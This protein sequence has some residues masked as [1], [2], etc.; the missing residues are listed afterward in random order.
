MTKIAVVVLNYNGKKFLKR[1]LPALCEN[2]GQ[3]GIIVADNK[4]GDD[5]IDFLAKEF[6]AV[7]L[8]QFKENLGFAGG[9]NKALEQIEAEYFA[10][11]NSDVEVSSNW[12]DPL[13]EFLESNDEYAAVQPKIK[14]GLNK[15]YFEHAGA[16]GGFV[17]ALGYPFCR[18]RIFQ[19]LEKDTGQYD[20]TVDIDWT[21]GACMLIRSEVFHQ[22]GGFDDNF[23]SHMEEIDLCWRIRSGGMKLAC[24]PKSTVYHVGGGTLDNSSP[25]KTYL[26]FRNGLSLLVKNLPLGQL[27]WKLPLRLIL[28]GM[29]AIKITFE[30]S[31]KH[32]WAIL[33]A[34]L[35]FYWELPRTLRK[36]R[37]TSPPRNIWILGEHF[38]NRKRKFDQFKKSQSLTR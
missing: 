3:A 38:L 4:S 21:S 5:S 14:S 36:R 24:L 29:A 7:E 33:K 18:G 22:N 12:L 15:T 17:D 19:H 31:P 26:N 20:N 2:S 9:Y 34:H 25:F 30:S 28:D 13:V 35:H 6:P 16:S 10:I 1:F 11:I 32:L 27:L 37:L 8:I 23:F